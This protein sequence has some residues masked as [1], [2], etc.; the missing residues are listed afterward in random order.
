[1]KIQ[2]DAKDSFLREEIYEATALESEIGNKENFA[3]IGVYFQSLNT[4]S[5]YEEP[6]YQVQLNLKYIK[7]VKI[8]NI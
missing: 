8:G 1:M 7:Q 5:I 2:E 3:Q 6:K 4:R